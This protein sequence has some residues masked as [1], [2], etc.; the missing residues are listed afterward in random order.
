MKNGAP[1]SLLGKLKNIVEI[2]AVIITAAAVSISA[3]FSYFEYK[4]SVHSK[5]VERSL[6]ISDDFLLDKS[7]SYRMG[8]SEAWR[9]IDLEIKNLYDKYSSSN[10]VEGVV[11]LD[12]YYYKIQESVVD[13]DLGEPLDYMLAIY[14]KASKCALEKACDESTINSLVKR[15]GKTF[16][17]TWHPYICDVRKKWSGAGYWRKSQRFY[18]GN[19]S[20]VCK[21]IVDKKEYERVLYHLKDELDD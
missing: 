13:M 15:H 9:E 6:K 21:V 7:W 5:K 16:F 12:I 14:Q 20:D 10:E 4:G 18:T 19:D 17:E 11:F 8:L 3:T 1:Q 2:V